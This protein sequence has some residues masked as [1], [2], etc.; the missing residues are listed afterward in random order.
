M[1]SK[2]RLN[3]DE[4]RVE[5]FD[6]DRAADEAGTV[7]AHMGTVAGASCPAQFCQTYDDTFCGLTRGCE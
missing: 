6:T 3:C 2:L 5:S 7:N 4:L 1:T